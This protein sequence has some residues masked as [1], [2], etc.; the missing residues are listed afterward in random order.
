MV[1]K[2]PYDESF[3]EENRRCTERSPKVVYG[4]M[5]ELMEID[6]LCDIGGGV[7]LWTSGFIELKGEKANLDAIRCLDGTY[8]DESQLLIPRECFIPTD[9]EGE[10]S[11]PGRRF[12]LVVSLEVAEHLSPERADS[13][14]KDITELGDT[15]MFSAAVPGQGG[16]NHINE[17]YMGYWTDRFAR[18]GYDPFDIVRPRIQDNPDV[19]FWYRQ[20]IIVFAKKGTRWHTVFSEMVNAPMLHAI[21]EDLYGRTLG[22]MQTFENE[23]DEARVDNSNLC[24]RIEASDRE[25]SEL[26]AIE[27]RLNREVSELYRNVSD[28]S[29]ELDMIKSRRT[30]KMGAWIRGKLSFLK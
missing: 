18:Y 9:L 2:E 27:E 19:P 7:G 15:V 21:S 1:E 5:L 24:S 12:D 4:I 22:Y 30:Y 13:F 16:T 28:L 8:I 10:I 3:Y 29:G 20:N 14:V 23:R 25:I 11:L 17:Q 26:R 6:S